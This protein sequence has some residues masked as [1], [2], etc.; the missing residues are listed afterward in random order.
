V[1]P[2]NHD[3]GIGAPARPHGGH[4]SC[5]FTSKQHRYYAENDLHAQGPYSRTSWTLFRIVE[6][7]TWECGI[8]VGIVALLR[9]PFLRGIHGSPLS[10]FWS[11][12]TGVAAFRDFWDRP[13]PSQ[14]SK[15][16]RP[17]AALQKPKTSQ[18]EKGAS[19]WGTNR[20]PACGRCAFQT[21]G[22]L[23]CHPSGNIGVAAGTGPPAL[24]TF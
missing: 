13:R 4:E 7:R 9:F 14:S 19:K 5:A 18:R 8:E 12:A 22:F 10:E 20:K 23:T 11:A 24:G 17:V 15:K 6:C 2:C 16:R 1:Q 21:K 3:A